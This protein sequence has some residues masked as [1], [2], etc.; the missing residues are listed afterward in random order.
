MLAIRVISEGFQLEAEDHSIV[1]V[2]WPDVREIVTFKR[3][4]FSYDEICLAFRV[5]DG[6]EWVELWESDRG[7]R[8]VCEQ[9][10]QR[11]PGVPADWYRTV[12]LPA[13]KPCERTLYR[14]TP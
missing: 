4:L 12:M 5:G 2:R 3:D 14:S 8:D 13:F 6:E 9:L 11:F 10:G 7:F 1:N